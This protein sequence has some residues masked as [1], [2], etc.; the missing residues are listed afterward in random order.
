[1]DKD[2]IR[3]KLLGDRYLNFAYQRFLAFKETPKYDA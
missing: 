1:M 3:K 2:I